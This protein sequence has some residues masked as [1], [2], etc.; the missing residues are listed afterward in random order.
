MKTL[1]FLSAT[2]ALLFFSTAIFAQTTY[3][4]VGPNGDGLDGGAWNT[5]SNWD[6]NAIPTNDNLSIVR[7]NSGAT[8][9]VTIN[10]N[11]AIR[12]LLITNNSQVSLTSDNPS[13]GRVLSF[14]GAA[15]TDS[16]VVASGSLL[17]L[18]A[19][20]IAF[21][22]SGGGA[23]NQQADISGTLETYDSPA[24][25][26]LNTNTGT[27]K[28]YVKSG[29]IIKNY[30]NNAWNIAASTLY[31]EAGAT[32]ESKA[33]T[34]RIPTA[35][36]NATSNVKITGFKDG[37][38]IAG[39][40]QNFGN[41]LW[42]APNQT[43]NALPGGNSQLPTN[44]R[45]TFEV[46]NTGGYEFAIL[47]SNSST[48]YTWDGDLLISGGRLALRT[49]SS[50]A[51]TLSVRHFT[52]DN[53]NSAHS[54]LI[55]QNASSYD[56]TFTVR[57]N[58]QIT[59]AQNSANTNIIEYQSRT[60]ANFQGNITQA[61]TG[62]GKI[63]RSA[64]V[65]SQF[66]FTGNTTQTV[67]LA[68]TDLFG[69]LT[70][71]YVS[72]AAG[73]T[74][75]LGNSIL[76]YTG[77]FALNKPES[78]LILGPN[79]VIKNTGVF[80]A[81]SQRNSPYT[82][83][84]AVGSRIFVGS[85]EGIASTG[86][87]GNIQSSSTRTFG[88]GINY[89]YTGSDGQITGT[90]L[91]TSI[92]GSLTLNLSAPSAKLTATNSIS[93]TESGN[94]LF[95][96]QG[97]LLLNNNNITLGSSTTVSGGSAN[98]FVAT[99]GTGEFRKTNPSGADPAPFT[100]TV[101]DVSGAFEYSPVTLDFNSVSPTT[102]GTVGVRV[103]NDAHPNKGILN[104]LGRYWNFNI[105][106]G[107]GTAY[108]YDATFTYTAAD[109]EP[110][111]AVRY[112][113][114]GTNWDI[115]SSPAS[116]SGLTFTISS[117]RATY[118]LNNINAFTTT[119]IST[120]VAGEWTGDA[121]TDDWE[122]PGNWS[123]GIL[124]DHTIDVVIPDVVSL[125]PGKYFPATP[126]FGTDYTVS[127][128]N[129]TI[130]SGASI[131][132]R[133]T[134]ILEVHGNFENNSSADVGSGKLKFAGTTAQTLSGNTNIGT[135]IL[136]NTAGVSVAAN[137]TVNISDKL[138]LDAGV[139][140]IP[141]NA[142]VVLKST[143]TKTA[144]VD[145]FDDATGATNT[146]TGISGNITIERYVPLATLV[147]STFPHLSRY[148][149]IGALTGG[150]ANKWNGQFNFNPIPVNLVDS[151]VVTPKPDCSPYFLASNSAFSNLFSFNE[152][153]ITD[154]YLRGWEARTTVAATPRGKG[155]AARIN[156]PAIINANRIL[157]E[158]GAYQNA[159]LN[160][161][162]LTITSTNTSHSKGEHL[163]ANPFWAPIEWS[164]VT[165][166]N[167]DATAYRYNPNTGTYNTYNLIIGSGLFST[168]E[169]FVVLP[170]DKTQSSFSISFPATA[171][172]NSDNNEFRRRSQPYAY[173]LD[174]V[175]TANNEE[176]NSL[177]AFDNLFTD[178][179]DNG[180]DARK[181]NSNGGVPTIYT[182]SLQNERGSILAIA[183]ATQQTVVPLGVIFQYDGTHTFTFNGIN[184][185]PVTSIIW[186]EDLETGTIQYLRQN[187][188]YT[189][190]ANIDDNP[191]RFLLHFAPELLINA[192]SNVCSNSE[193]IISINER[194]GLDWA[195]ELKDENNNVVSSGNFSN[196]EIE[197]DNLS[198]GVYTL[199]LTN[200]IS[201]YQTTE[202]ITIQQSSTIVDADVAVSNT[203]INVGESVVIDASNSTGNNATNIDAGDG[204][205]Y[206][207]ET[208]VT[209]TYTAPG[210]YTITVFANNDD[211]DDAATIQ[212]TVNDIST[213]N[214]LN[215]GN[216]NLTVYGN[217]NTLYLQ[218]NLNKDALPV[219]VEIYN[220]LGQLVVSEAL[221]ASY[222]NIY[223]ITLDNI[224][225]GTYIA[226]VITNDVS[227]S[228]RILVNN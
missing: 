23:S 137:V 180:Y 56:I 199:V 128:R 213:G 34:V 77:D 95:L 108:N 125:D 226:K 4:W 134:T 177:I 161:I 160:N 217:L 29:G 194:G 99:N 79:A 91:P 159:D 38:T 206:N 8:I 215:S 193:G 84:T 61:G 132:I 55:F 124:P 46:R 202:T 179:F 198:G 135:L 27:P 220:T 13:N 221:T 187:N 72:N 133:A 142:D 49:F 165:G 222:K 42:D 17:S 45:G 112:T 1:K 114:T 158:K 168:N 225:S 104:L 191:D 64:S 176:D 203:T 115:V 60:V 144:Y 163:V 86:A 90:G 3:T 96:T 39:L 98:S 169:A 57:G 190:S 212:L 189:F 145:D 167:L 97:I 214:I 120:C 81:S 24:T 148:H 93:L 138:Q 32:Y 71:I 143:E 205:I 40:G 54:Q 73:G 123:C 66:N 150:T 20:N 210:T 19:V 216:N 53:T 118:P 58:T 89:I 83:T 11:Q 111:D 62:M 197:F 122:T 224:T 153:N 175:V 87:T 126:V 21:S 171:R 63:G 16:W 37:G 69:T 100:Y 14:R 76:E 162:S 155:F 201:G 102:S 106:S 94:R 10:A 22:T 92:T 47:S 51:T 9:T 182:R 157:S 117:N 181:I 147:N 170:L 227:V 113:G 25:Y 85:Q 82:I 178:N 141:A 136:D 185:F 107:L 33:N 78:G 88:A 173:G 35:T 6:Q 223:S 80:Y 105:V 127:V 130:E 31:F 36:W 43:I 207:N 152:T 74:V 139:L 129:I 140:T 218:Q 12:Q 59:L 156:D 28:V 2:L 131:N 228:K 44:I 65:T 7:F 70:T 119:N 50:I 200:T 30:D 149:Y 26:V 209:H 146:N 208:V 67:S 184:D 109:G 204:T 48:T 174:I 188:V 192:A 164:E 183:E 186:L 211:C 18:S 110:G 103:T 101:G 121:F 15:N 172:R 52:L 116:T 154:C 151:T 219:T 68:R 195:Y 166:T 41:F 196:T 75:D 5:A